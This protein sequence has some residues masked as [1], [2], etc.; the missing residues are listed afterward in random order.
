MSNELSDYINER[1]RQNGGEAPSVEEINRWANE[2]MSQCNS[3]AVDDFEGYS[4]RQMH[5]IIHQLWSADSV[6][7]IKKLNEEDFEQIPIF[8]QAYYLLSFLQREGKLKLTAT[9]AIPP[10]IVKEMYALG[11]LQYDIESGITNLTK[12]IDS[13]SVQITHF[14]LKLSRCIKERNGV[15]TMTKKGKNVFTDKQML[16]EELLHSFTCQYNFAYFDAFRNRIAAGLGNG[17]SLILLAKYGDVK[18]SHRF[19]AEKYYIAFP[20]VLYDFVESYGSVERVSGSCYNIRT[21]ERYMAHFGLVTIEEK[22]KYFGDTF[23]TKT[24]LFDKMISVAKP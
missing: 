14:M 20:D 8:R 15:M 21:F 1:I 11:T 2:Y 22:E 17:F 6:V 18:R 10:R 16:L 23:I 4:P 3:R 7:K 9:K 19:Y 5:L 12:E 13:Q 24:D